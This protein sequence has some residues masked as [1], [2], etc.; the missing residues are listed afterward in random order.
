VHGAGRLDLP[1]RLPDQD[2]RALRTP[3]G[4]P[5]A[6]TVA[7]D[8][9]APHAAARTFRLRAADGD[10]LEHALP[11]IDQNAYLDLFAAAAP[12]LGTAVPI[13]RRPPEP[14]TFTAPLQPLL[15]EPVSP[16]IPFGYGDPCV[17]HVEGEDEPWRLVV[18]SNDAA[19]AFPILRSRDLRDWRLCGHVFPEGRTPPWTL[20]GEHRADF[21]APELHR[22]GAEYWLVFA[23]REHDRS[24]AI[25]LARASDPDGPY[26]ADPEPLVRGGVIDAHILFGREG[27]PWLL[28]KR[29]DNGVWPRRL[30]ALLHREPG[31]VGRLFLTEEDRRTACLLLTLWP[32]TAGLE[33]M[34]QFFQLQPLI[35][36]VIHDFAAFGERLSALAGLEA[37]IAVIRSAMK[38]RVFAQALA[39]DGRSLLGAPQ[40]VLENDQP[41]EAHLIE[42]VWAVEHEGLCYL[43]YAANDFSTPH[44]GIGVAVADHPHGPYRKLPEPL[45]RSTAEWSGP[46]HPSIVRGPDGRWRMFLHAF[47]PGEA[48]YKVFRALLTAEVQFDGEKIRLV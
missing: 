19:D 5:H 25:G 40:L 48:G 4:A 24:L 26:E 47:R 23:A 44:Y 3:A 28:W 46:G 15:T 13:N 1:H 41:W 35:E 33:P 2:L 11:A 36:A 42:G 32:W 16:D 30:C 12:V 29:D 31:L 21:W 17:L 43:F 22:V 20:T 8:G 6:F 9:D 45:L 27:E 37:E 34:E 10:G 18:T 39:P 7:L 38:T 14:V